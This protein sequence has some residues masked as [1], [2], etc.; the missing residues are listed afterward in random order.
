MSI[1]LVYHLGKRYFF[2]I[3]NNAILMDP[4]KG[5]KL[6]GKFS[7][8]YKF[9][10]GSY[11]IIYKIDSSLHTIYILRIKHRKDVYDSLI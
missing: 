11:R 5:K 8:F 9:R 10:F 6:K 1:Y 3:V 2:K 7:G 4:L